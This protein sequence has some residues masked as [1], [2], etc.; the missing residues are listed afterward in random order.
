MADLDVVPRTK[1]CAQLGISRSTIKRWIAN[2]G[3]PKPLKASGRQ[4]LFS[5]TEVN[6][7]IAQMENK[8]G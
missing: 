3:F 8:N 4:P 2:R 1:L 5:K 6:N 7:W